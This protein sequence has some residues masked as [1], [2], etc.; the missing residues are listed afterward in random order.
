MYSRIRVLPITFY[1]Y[2]MHQKRLFCVMFLFVDPYKSQSAKAGA[3]SDIGLQSKDT[4]CV[5][6][7]PIFEL[8]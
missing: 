8:H 6:S 2:N 3:H 7:S 5:P 1:H 4:R